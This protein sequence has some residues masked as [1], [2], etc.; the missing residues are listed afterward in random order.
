MVGG[1][2]SAL[3]PRR[4][5]ALLP[6]PPIAPARQESA[7][8]RVDAVLRKIRDSDAGANLSKEDRGAVD[9]LL[10]S[11]EDDFAA[12]PTTGRETRSVTFLAIPNGFLAGSNNF[13]QCFDNS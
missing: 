12:G 8:E 11:L 5:P 6:P 9:G 3:Q 2:G 1:G 4:P 7:A 10:A 13:E